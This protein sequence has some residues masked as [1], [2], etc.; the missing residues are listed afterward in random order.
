MGARLRKQTCS[1]VCLFFVVCLALKLVVIAKYSDGE[2]TQE[3]QKQMCVCSHAH[4][5][6]QA[7]L[8]VLVY[9]T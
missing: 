2:D 7:H 3:D 6:V 1:F 4:V 9:S 8:C 5:C